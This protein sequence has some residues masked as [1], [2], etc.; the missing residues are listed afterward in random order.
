MLAVV[1]EDVLAGLKDVPAVRTSMVC[2]G[3]R[4]GCPLQFAL[5]IIIVLLLELSSVE[6]LRATTWVLGLLI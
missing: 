2:R 6:G 5:L 4:P 1:L 3:C